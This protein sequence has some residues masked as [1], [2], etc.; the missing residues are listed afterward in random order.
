[1]MKPDPPV[2]TPRFTTPPGRCVVLY[3]GHCRFCTLGMERL[4]RVARPGALEAVDFQLPGALDRFPGLTH[5]DCMRQMYLVRPD[6]RVHGGFEAAVEAVRT[7]PILGWLAALYY[8]PGLRQLCDLAYKFVAARRYRIMGKTVE[9]GQCAEG[10]CSL[11]LPPSAATPRDIA[12][13]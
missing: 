3:D 11:H 12:D 10:T 5:D 7:R 13:M 8:L 1:M 9:S 6:G 4:L 2:H